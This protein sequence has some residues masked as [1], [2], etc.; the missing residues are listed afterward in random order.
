MPK[1]NFIKE[2]FIMSKKEPKKR[3]SVKRKKRIAEKPFDFDVEIL[4]EM[5][6]GNLDKSKCIRVSITP[7]AVVKKDLD[8]LDLT[9]KDAHLLMEQLQD[10]CKRLDDVREAYFKLDEI[11]GYLSTMEST[12]SNARDM[13]DGANW[14]DKLDGIRNELEEDCGDLETSISEL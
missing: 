7:D 6:G 8:Y 5:I 13:L 14:E 11:D 10:A 3:P 4:T 9:P 1:N 2:D 12:V